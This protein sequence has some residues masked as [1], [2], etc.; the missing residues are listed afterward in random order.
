MDRCR[1]IRDRKREHDELERLLVDR[2]GEGKRAWLYQVQV[3]H[4][5]AT[6]RERVSVRLN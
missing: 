6:S 5:Q 2:G 4:S 3:H 1:V